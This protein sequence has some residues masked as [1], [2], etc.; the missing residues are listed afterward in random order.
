[1]FESEIV[2]KLQSEVMVRSVYC[3]SEE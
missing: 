2:G 3:I 1:V